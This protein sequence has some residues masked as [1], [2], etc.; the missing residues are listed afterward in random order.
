MEYSAKTIQ[1][2]L[3]NGDPKGIKIAEI[4]SRIVKAVYVPRNE[5]E[6]ALKRE[7]FQNV[8]IYFLFGKNETEAK[9]RVY[10]GETEEAVKRF[11]N[12]D[13]EKEFWE[14][15]IFITTSN[16]RLTKAD[17]KFLERF[18][19]DECVEIGRYNTDQQ[20][21][22]QSHVLETTKADLMDIFETMK[23]LL[24]TLGFNIFE[25]YEKPKELYLCKGRGVVA[26]GAQ[27][28]E[29]FV[30]Y[31]GSEMASDSVPSLEKGYADLRN[32]LV[33]D[34][35]VEL[36]DG[37]Y[38]FQKNHTFSVPSPASSCILGRPSN[39]WVDWKNADGKTLN[40]IK[41]SNE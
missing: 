16:N 19:Y 24:T 29:G 18:C 8:G 38:V 10:I 7:E 17:V 3:P 22:K 9:P 35:I 23:I 28:D 34:K 12:H 31:S 33:K 25:E 40:D 27:T 4:T 15:F 36:K 20:K 26:K 6:N 32:K 14:Q 21:P 2:F 13:K 39:G 37:K 5:V 1:I 11:K 41:K 30:V